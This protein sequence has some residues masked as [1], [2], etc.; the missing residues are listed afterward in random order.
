MQKFQ[1]HNNIVNDLD[2]HLQTKVSYSTAKLQLLG[3][4]CGEFHSETTS[5]IM[6]IM[7]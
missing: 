4:I 7:M 2:M 3:E 5:I 1:I 6:M